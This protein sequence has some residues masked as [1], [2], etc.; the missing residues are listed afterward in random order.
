MVDVERPGGSELTLLAINVCK[1]LNIGPRTLLIG[2]LLPDLIGMPW[3]ASN[4][5][6][7]TAV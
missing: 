2:G 5:E 1:R 4:I 3:F 7:V 6:Q